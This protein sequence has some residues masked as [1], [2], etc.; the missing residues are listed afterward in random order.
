LAVV[1]SKIGGSGM[2][3]KEISIKGIEELFSLWSF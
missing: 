2:Q 3:G 1:T